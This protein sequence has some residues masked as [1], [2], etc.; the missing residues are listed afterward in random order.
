MIDWEDNGEG[1]LH[2]V[3]ANGPFAII[4]EANTADEGTWVDTLMTEAIDPVE[5]VLLDVQPLVITQ[6][7]GAVTTAQSVGAILTSS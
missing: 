5:H 2:L 6:P 4:D 1:E 3:P 7:I